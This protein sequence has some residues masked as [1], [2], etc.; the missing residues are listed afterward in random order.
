[1]SKRKRKYSHTR[2]HKSKNTRRPP[3][4]RQFRQVKFGTINVTTVREDSRLSES[5]RQAYRAGLDVCATQETKRRNSGSKLV[6]TG[7][8]DKKGNP[9][10]YEFHWI[11]YKRS[12]ANTESLAVV[13]FLVRKHPYI[14]VE[15]IDFDLGPGMMTLTALVFGI[16][17]FFINNYMYTETTNQSR[18]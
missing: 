17:Y 9:I 4:T 11:G 6:E 18:I 1:M 5:A 10:Y 15:D 2:N 8:F 7:Y 14:T 16:R 13:G 3:P 12:P